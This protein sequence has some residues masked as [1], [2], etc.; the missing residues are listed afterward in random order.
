M[1]VG[2]R[3][4]CLNALHN[5]NVRP[6]I[7]VRISFGTWRDRCGFAYSKGRSAPA[8]DY[9]AIGL[10]HAPPASGS[11]VAPNRA[12][13]G[14]YTVLAANSAARVRV[15]FKKRHDRMFASCLL[16]PSITDIARREW[17]V[18]VG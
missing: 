2:H 17:W 8:A 13:H 9:P 3:I 18:V 5:C 15:G 12:R 7:R 10:S 4:L 14:F 1:T 16:Y 6:A 11:P